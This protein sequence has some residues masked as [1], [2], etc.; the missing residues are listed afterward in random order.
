MKIQ[1]TTSTSWRYGLR[2]GGRYS[3]R[4][5]PLF[6]IKLLSLAITSFFGPPAHDLPVTSYQCWVLLFFSLP[7]G[8]ELKTLHIPRRR[9]RGMPAKYP[10]FSTTI[11]VLNILPCVR[12]GSQSWFRKPS[13]Y[14][15]LLL[16][17]VP[18]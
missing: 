13:H 16:T 1:G 6:V 3:P 15:I 12:P 18:H 10:R 7:S 4:S 9:T 14:S 17:L 5:P 2:E 11:V 8:R